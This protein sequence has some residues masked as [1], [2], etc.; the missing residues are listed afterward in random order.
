MERGSHGQREV[1]GEG[2]EVNQTSPVKF[3]F[4]A[5]VSRSGSTFLAK[6]M[7]RHLE[8]V[9]VLPEFRLV[10]ILL[11]HGE[12]AVQKM[13][14]GELAGL[15]E[16]DHQFYS[17]GLSP[18]EVM[19]AA[20]RS[21]G[22]GIM[23]FVAELASLYRDRNQMSGE[24]FVVQIG[25]FWDAF[26]CGLMKSFSSPKLLHIFRDPRGVANSLLRS[27]DPYFFGE[28][29]GRGDAWFI[30]REYS[31]VMERWRSYLAGG[32]G[33]AREIKYEEF[34]RSPDEHIRELADW[35]GTAFD[36]AG[37][38]GRL[39]IGEREKPL[40]PLADGPPRTDRSRAWQGELAAWQ[41]V[42]LETIARPVMMA[43]GYEPWFTNRRPA[44]V[45]Y[46]Y[47]LNGWA[48]HL[49]RTILHYTRRLVFYLVNPGRMRVRAMTYLRSWSGRKK[50]KG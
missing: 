22:Q 17:L 15:T 49:A 34:L 36:P 18:H 8:G 35:T 45:R 25:L 50:G 3:L 13:S 40:H 41:G 47:L 28:V 44:G 27:K 31:H 1:A 48:V 9:V 11:S 24:L 38:V 5:Y 30:A 39:N 7:A 21:Q 46:L 19:E 29:M 23:P 6:L 16:L 4:L 26:D 33:N 20:E 32:G 42:T 43:R 2:S 10:E 12:G 14:A 37:Q